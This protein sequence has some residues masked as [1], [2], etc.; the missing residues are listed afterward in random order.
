MAYACLRYP[1][2]DQLLRDMMG[3]G[4]GHYKCKIGSY[5]QGL[6]LMPAWGILAETNYSEISCASVL[7]GRIGCHWRAIASIRTNVIHPMDT[8]CTHRTRYT[9][10]GYT[11][12]TSHSLYTLWIRIIHI[13]HVI[14]HIKVVHI[15]HMMQAEQWCLYEWFVTYSLYLLDCTCFRVGCL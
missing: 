11:L 3:I 9:P 13:A 7:S 8:H 12:K 14:H 5:I 2:I 10:Y 15:T 6:W 4:Q 1:S